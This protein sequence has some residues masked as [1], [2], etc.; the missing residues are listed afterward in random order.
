MEGV[1]IFLDDDDDGVLDPDELR[2]TTNA[3]GA[4][5]FADLTP[6]QY[7]IR[8][9][10]PNGFEQTTPGGDGAHRVV[11]EGRPRIEVTVEATD[12]GG[13]RAAG[14]NATAVG[15]IVNALPW[16]RGNKPGLYDALQVPLTP[17][18]GHLGA[19]SNA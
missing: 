16:L 3:Q 4:Y 14:G 17:A 18:I 19:G 12:E 15:R 8:E 11:I 7:T 1:T 9:I 10:V 5:S 6:F 2:T 13:N